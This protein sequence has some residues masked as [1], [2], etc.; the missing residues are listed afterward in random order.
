M[1]KIISLSIAAAS[2]AAATEVVE[3]EQITTISTATKTEKKID[4]V[5]A[6][7]EVVTEDEIKKMGAESL[8][9]ILNNTAGVNVQYGTFPSA[10][11][12]SKS[13]ISLRG[14]G[15]KGTLFLVDGK[16][17]G[18]E[19]ANPY[20]LDR[21]PASQ[22][23]KIEIVKGPMST[24]Y[25][26]DATGGV[27]NIITKKPKSGKPQIDFGVRYGQNGNG[28]DQNKNVNFSVRGKENKL[29]YSLYLNKT[30]TTPYTQ[31]ELADVYVKQVGGPNHGTIQKPSNITD[32]TPSAQL[33]SLSDTY[34]HDVTYKEESDIFTYGG[35]IEYDLS[36]AVIAGFEL[37]AFTEEREGSYIG[38]FHPSNVSPAPGQKIPVFN[39]PVDSE[40]DNERMDMAADV[41]IKASDELN[42]FF[43]AYQSYYEKRNKTTTPY[44]NELKYTSQA[45]SAQNGMDANVDIKSIEAMA[46]YLF[47][48]NH[49]LTFGAEYREED[50]E[51]TVFDPD[52]NAMTGKNVDYKAL[53]LQD[54]WM[55]DESLNVIL[56][57]RYDDISNADAKATFKLGAVKNFSKALN[58]RANIA[59]GYRA[60][61]IR[62]LY[63]FKNTPSGAQRGAEVIDA[64]V[65]KT[66]VYDL[67]PES[68]LTYEIG[69]SGTLGATRYDLALF[70]NDIE[71]LI[72]EVN[73]GAY[74]TFENISSAKTYGAEFTLSRD[75]SDTLSG[76]LNWSELGSENDQTGKELE[77][78]PDRII[79]AK[80]T[81]Q[82]TSDIDTSL[83]VKYVGEQYYKKTV[84]RGT[85]AQAIVDS[86]TNA[87]TTVDWNINYAY[88]KNF[89]IYGGV[90]NIADEKI[91]DVLGSTSGRYFFTGMRVSF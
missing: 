19:V 41:K 50:R 66:E 74:Y 26:A 60:P 75:F 32:G 38:Y 7:V 71:D 84:N 42:L 69:T 78:N 64:S 49:L 86:K 63:I 48:E 22:I 88:S 52:S 79:G 59:Q 29:G 47:R 30:A 39:I 85:P 4:G 43:R 16:R 87:F 51:G 89:S 54:E 46:N 3:L 40:D 73:K 91:D 5:A 83:G 20:D 56:G 2:F 62:E 81:Y 23:E 17:L 25:G 18:G 35:R 80:F 67:Q 27:V 15:A 90:N 58:V 77:F 11:S 8:K 14:M 44:W 72:S 37:N 33:K 36:D 1:K 57:A 9:D 28:D 68:T 31:K 70:Y 65:G 82:A 53:Y 61:D 21:I 6:S 45:A 12:K 24:L 10:S 13:S 55:V 34:L 76:S